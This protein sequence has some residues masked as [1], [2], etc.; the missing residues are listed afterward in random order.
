MF[1]F[2]LGVWY[3]VGSPLVSFVYVLVRLHRSFSLL[4]SL[5]LKRMKKAWANPNIINHRTTKNGKTSFAT[6][7]IITK[8]FPNDG[9]T[10]KNSKNLKF[11]KK[12]ESDK[13]QRDGSVPVISQYMDV[14]MG[15]EYAPTSIKD[16]F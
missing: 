4:L 1:V 15:K 14:I 16:N 5:D 9:N 13:S 3:N 2:E 7:V 6:P 11:N 10:R 12:L 8:Y